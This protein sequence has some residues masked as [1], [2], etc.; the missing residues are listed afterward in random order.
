MW[1][2]RLAVVAALCSLGSLEDNG[3]NTPDVPDYQKCANRLKKDLED[4]LSADMRSLND[5]IQRVNDNTI[6]RVNGKVEQLCGGLV[7]TPVTQEDLNATK[8][9]LLRFLNEFSREAQRRENWYMA[10][11]TDLEK[12]LADIF[13]ATRLPT[14]AEATPVAAMLGTEYPCEDSTF[15]GN[16]YG[17][18]ESAV[19]FNKCY[20]ET[21]AYH[22]CRS[23]TDNDK[24]PE[25]G[26]WRYR[27]DTRVV[28]SLDVLRFFTL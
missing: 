7:R 27:N 5:T 11:I 4:K 15:P 17:V 28:N 16:N 13:N 21:V 1:F 3:S 12:T 22:C 18:C 26:P 24:L 23:C 6:A 9:E 14:P 8:G 19:K 2:L 20:Q 10:K 25:I